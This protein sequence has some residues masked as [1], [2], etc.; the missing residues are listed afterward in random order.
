MKLSNIYSKKRPKFNLEKHLNTIRNRKHANYTN[1]IV[2]EILNKNTNSQSDSNSCYKYVNI[3]TQ[4]LTSQEKK[5][6]EENK[7]GIKHS[8]PKG[9]CTVIGD[10]MVAGIDE[11]KMSIKPLI[12]VRSFSGATFSDMYHYL[13]PILEKKLTM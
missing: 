4:E 3:T 6:E 10:S 5:T 11:R 2:K 9:K 13:V 7:N 1:N 12:K 8:W